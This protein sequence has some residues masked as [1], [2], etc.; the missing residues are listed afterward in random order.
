[1]DVH[2]GRRAGSF[3]V[4]LWLVAAPCLVSEL[5]LRA[6]PRL[7]ASYKAQKRHE[8]ERAFGAVYHELEFDRQ[9]GQALDRRLRLDSLG[10]PKI[11]RNDCDEPRFEDRAEAAAKKQRRGVS[12]VGRCARAVRLRSRI[13]NR[14]GRVFRTLVDIGGS[15]GALVV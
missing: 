8:H 5:S 4:S 11:A 6:R 2:L 14:T 12:R 13:V 9:N 3:A 15:A 7:L 10:T 1:M